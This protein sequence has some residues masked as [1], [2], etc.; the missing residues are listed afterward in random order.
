M[1]SASVSRHRRRRARPSSRL[2]GFS[3][4]VYSKRKPRSSLSIFLMLRS[5]FF[6]ALSVKWKEDI[7]TGFVIMLV[8]NLIE[9][10]TGQA[11]AVDHLV[12]LFLTRTI[13]DRELWLTLER[14]WAELPF[15][16]EKG[17]LSKEADFM[18][19]FEVVEQI[20]ERIVQKLALKVM[21]GD[22]SI[23]E[24]FGWFI[25]FGG[26]MSVTNNLASHVARRMDRIR[27]EMLEQLGD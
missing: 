12:N 16:K 20:Q 26:E 5:L 3:A 24:I 17:R 25:F 15:V 2:I 13:T 4:E 23:N 14:D 22:L 19:H 11:E 18:F 21:S 9:H 8:M 27:R 10:A 6:G 7:L 1:R